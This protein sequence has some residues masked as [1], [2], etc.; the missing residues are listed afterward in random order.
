M[1]QHRTVGA[2][3][4]PQ[5]GD[6]DVRDDAARSLRRSIRLLSVIRRAEPARAGGAVRLLVAPFGPHLSGR[7]P[8]R[9][10]PRSAAPCA[11][12]R[13][14]SS[15]ELFAGV[16]PLG[17]P[18]IAARFPR[19]YLDLN[20]EPYELDPEL[21]HDPLPAHANTQSIRV[22]GGL[23]TVARIVADGEEIYR[24]AAARCTTFWRASSSCISRS[25][26]R[27]RGSSKQTRGAVRLRGSDRLPFDAVGER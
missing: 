5:Q 7:I 21:V 18:L 12:P 2:G 13:T 24:D 6:H 16:A 1:P 22:A 11:N 23:G 27:W 14:A 15:I 8:G 9:V 19:A 10:A 25:T 3:R 17:A 4:A 26:A 20:R